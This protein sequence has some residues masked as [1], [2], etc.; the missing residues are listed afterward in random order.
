MDDFYKIAD[1]YITFGNTFQY[2]LSDDDVSRTL[3]TQIA[4]RDIYYTQLLENHK[5]LTYVRGKC[6]EIHKWLFFWLVII[7]CCFG[8]MIVYRI[9]NKILSAEDFN[10]VIDAIPIVIT[11]LVSFVSTIIA[12]PLTIT[13]FLFNS[14]EDDN[15]TTLIQ[16]TQDHDTEGINLFKDRFIPKQSS[17]SLQ[18]VEN[19]DL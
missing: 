8:I 14:K 1:R 12:I 16:H 9:I 7:A 18:G 10:S 19:D 11:A 6:K 2:I 4:K 13:K 17:V 5:K 15:I 3:A